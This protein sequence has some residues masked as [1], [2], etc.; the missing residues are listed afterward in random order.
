MAVLRAGVRAYTDAELLGHLHGHMLASIANL[1][2]RAAHGHA[3]PLLYKAGVR[4]Q[5]EPPGSE[6]WQ[7]PHESYALHTA[8]CEDLATWFVA[9]RHLL[10]DHAWQVHVKFINPTLRHIL[11]IH[12]D[13]RLEDPSAKLGMRGPG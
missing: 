5:R 12:D 13:G 4:Y 9:E 10:G 1:A 6:V 11:A 2:R 7:L 8:D 3:L